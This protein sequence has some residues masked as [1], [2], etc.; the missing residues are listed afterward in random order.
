MLE[1]ARLIDKH[2]MDQI[3]RRVE[4]QR[5]IRL[6]RAPRKHL[7][8]RR[9]PVCSTCSS[10]VS[11]SS[12]VPRA[13]KGETQET[14]DK[15]PTLF[16]AAARMSP[17]PAPSPRRYRSVRSCSSSERCRHGVTAKRTGSSSMAM[18]IAFWVAARLRDITGTG[19]ATRLRWTQPGQ[20]RV[21]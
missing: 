2:D 16:T 18:A 7:P 1:R 10:S 19:D 8:A 11:S 9:Q 5:Q 21:E 3:R 13:T 20:G 6:A 17:P 4:Q 12:N 14:Q 15:Q